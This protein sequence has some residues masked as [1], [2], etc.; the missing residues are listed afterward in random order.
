MK[1]R[2]VAAEIDDVMD[3]KLNPGP[4]HVR[5]RMVLNLLVRELEATGK[6]LLADGVPTHLLPDGKTVT[7][8][9]GADGYTAFISS[10]GLP[11]CDGWDKRLTE[12][13]LGRSLRK[14]RTLGLSHYDIREH[15]AY[16]NEWG[17]SFIRLGPD[18]K[19][20]RHVNGEFGLLWETADA[21][22]DTDLDMVNAYSGG[23]LSWT[24]ED[25]LI[26]HVLGVGV[27]S[28]STGVGRTHALNAL[29]CFM[30]AL[31]M[32]ERVKTIPIP[33]LNGPSGSRKSSIATG[34]GR[35][36]SG[37]GL[38]FRVTSCPDSAKE[39]QNVLCN[40]RGIVCLDEFQNARALGS[41]LKSY[42]TGAAIRIR[43]L[44]T[45]SGERVFI[46]DSA[47]FLTI[48]DDAWMDEATT[49]RLL[50]IDMG[51]P[52]S[53]GGVG[54]WRADFFVMKDWVD[55]NLRNLGWNE[56]V[57]RLSAAMRLLTQAMANGRADV[58]V[59]HRMS[60]FWG[61]VLSI[62]EQESPECLAQMEA[63]LT[64]IDDSQNVAVGNSDDLLPK[65]LEWLERNT[66]CHKRWMTATEIG[67]EILR[68]WDLTSLGRGAGPEMRKILSSSFQLSRK[69]K[70]SQLY[71]E[72]LGL[73]TRENKK[74]KVK[75]FWFDPPPSGDVSRKLEVRI[76]GVTL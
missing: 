56:L 25:V 61:F 45:T 23:A 31:A 48:N 14:T 20:T 75:E 30:L 27:F 8:T 55:G 73:Q 18:G 63:T 9:A 69:L 3:S 6:L 1:L 39:V 37:A 46:P 40:A 36:V 16:L 21:P 53:S 50:R 74:R 22:H 5:N 10:C 60:D 17:G 65:I 19:V 4:Q 49:K 66:D 7:L 43:I 68:F 33:F 51:Q 44:Y 11:P 41:L 42:T 32:K 47:L 72:R 71:V 76:D 26:K 24:D 34:I 2:A 54:A 28:E 62:A 12:E 38:E 70:T 15:V 52:E 13:L 29:L 35:V 67:N 64:A 59:R 57:C 58:Q